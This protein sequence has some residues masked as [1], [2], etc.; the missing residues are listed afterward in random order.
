MAGTKINYTAVARFLASY[1]D[2]MT[3]LRFRE[4]SIRSLLFYQAELVRLARQLQQLKDYD[5]RMHPEPE[6]R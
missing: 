4:L 2:E 5:A 1:P 6:K 3:L